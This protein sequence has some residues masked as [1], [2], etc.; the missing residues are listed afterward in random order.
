MYNWQKDGVHADWIVVGLKM[1]NI[2]VAKTVNKFQRVIRTQRKQMFAI[3]VLSFGAVLLLKLLSDAFYTTNNLRTFSHR[4]RPIDD[5]NS[6]YD[7]VEHITR[8]PGY[9]Y[10]DDSLISPQNNVYLEKHKLHYCK[11]DKN[12]GSSMQVCTSLINCY[13][14]VL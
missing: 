4:F 2:P 13:L 3:C 5:G 6:L 14:I 9:R 7:K 1:P 8:T 10:F 11:I 12:M